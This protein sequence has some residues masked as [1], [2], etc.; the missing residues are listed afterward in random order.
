[1]TEA[2]RGSKAI[3]FAEEKGLTLR[4]YADPTERARKGLT[5]DEAREVAREDPN[6][7]WLST[8]DIVTAGAAE[9]AGD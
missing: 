7:I 1:M 5:P 8:A 9:R 3:A 2:M 4:K 6:L